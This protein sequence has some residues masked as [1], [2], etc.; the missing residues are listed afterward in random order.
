[1]TALVGAGA[2]VRTEAGTYHPSGSA[3]PR[4]TAAPAPTPAPMAPKPPPMGTLVVRVPQA[5]LDALDATGQTRSDAARTV[6][7]R[8]LEA[9]SG[10][11]AGSG[12]GTRRSA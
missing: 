10:A 3:T 5:M 8:G 6:L 7:A 12:S 1:M 4:P 2:V 11:G 9:V